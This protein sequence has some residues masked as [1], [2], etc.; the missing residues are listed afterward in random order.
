M[1]ALV[2]AG[3]DPLAGATAEAADESPRDQLTHREAIPLCTVVVL[4]ILDA[5]GVRALPI[6]GAGFIALGLRS[7]RQSSDV[8]V[9]VAP[10]GAEVALRAL[11]DAGWRDWLPAPLTQPFGNSHSLT[12]EHDVWPCSLD[13]HVTF[14]GLLAPPAVS[15][16]ALWAGRTTVDIAHRAV[17]VPCRPHALALEVLH[18]LRDTPATQETAVVARLVE[19]LP[20]PLSQAEIDLLP[21][22]AERTDS[23]ETLG[24]L[25]ELLGHPHTP[26]TPST[27]RDQAALARWRATQRAGTAPLGWFFVLARQNPLRATVALWQHAWLSDAQARTWAK[28]K[29]IDY[30]SRADVQRRRLRMAV[31]GVRLRLGRKDREDTP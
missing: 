18:S 6:K 22:F 12:L 17:E 24:A 3:G 20:E 25:L 16:D 2:G 26:H 31:E 28:A 9:L 11:A 1:T 15:F 21:G 10:D 13:L 8:D 7:D 30:V 19:A 29:R 14:P 4:G 5:V 23:A 27:T